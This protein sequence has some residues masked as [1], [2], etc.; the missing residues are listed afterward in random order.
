MLEFLS[1]IPIFEGKTNLYSFQ[2]N[3]WM[4]VSLDL[5]TK[6]RVLMSA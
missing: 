5:E 6:A 4:V 1:Y 2:V 3:A